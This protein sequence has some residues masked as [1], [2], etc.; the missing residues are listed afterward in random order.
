MRWSSVRL[1]LRFTTLA[2]ASVLAGCSTP[3]LT[4]DR[5]HPANPQAR[6]ASTPP[7]GPRLGKDE[8]TRETE[9]RFA[10]GNE[11]QTNEPPPI[12]QAGAQK[13]QPLSAVNEGAEKMHAVSVYVCPMHP[14]VR[15]DK[16]GNC[17]KCGMKLVERKEASSAGH[18]H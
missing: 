7:A 8:R 1:L 11:V 12:Q 15:S 18:Q 4:F 3:P 14:E 6:E 5:T 17:P 13:H 9:R 16:P 10:S 2:S